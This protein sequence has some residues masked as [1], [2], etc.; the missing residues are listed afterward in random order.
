[1]KLDIRGDQADIGTV[2]LHESQ[3][4]NEYLFIALLGVI[5]TFVGIAVV[6]TWV[7]GRD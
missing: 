4:E 1:M 2:I 3:A 5:A 6:M 7:R